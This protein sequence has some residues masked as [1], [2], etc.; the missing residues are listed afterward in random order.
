MPHGPAETENP[1][2]GVPDWLLAFKHG[3][4]DESVPEHRDASSSSH[5]LLLEPRANVVSGKHDIFHSLPEGQK[6]RYLFEDQD[7]KGSCRRRTGTVVP[8]AEKLVI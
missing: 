2:K 5:E 6:L 3:L 7:Y 8:K 4:V 1:N